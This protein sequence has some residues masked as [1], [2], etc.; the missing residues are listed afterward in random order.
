VEPSPY[1][2]GKTK[3]DQ[4]GQYHKDGNDK[5]WVHGTLSPGSK[6][7]AHDPVGHMM[8]GSSV[9]DGKLPIPCGIP[10]SITGISGNR[11]G[12]IDNKSTIHQCQVLSAAQTFHKLLSL[13]DLRHFNC[14]AVLLP[15]H[16]FKFVYQPPEKF[17]ISI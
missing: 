11:H 2:A 17:D 7:T 16:S 13:H 12:L 14:L 5:L 8:I 15:V 10:P 4:V 9:L 1:L 6:K 3:A